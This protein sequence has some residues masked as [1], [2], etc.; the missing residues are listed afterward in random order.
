MTEAPFDAIVIGTGFGGAVAACRLAQAGKKVCILER[1]RRYP[2]HDF[3]RPAKRSDNLPYTARFAWAIDHGLWDVKDLQGVLAVQ[4]AGYGGGSLV[5]ANVHLRPPTRIFATAPDGWPA[6]YRDRTE[7]EPF[8]DIVAAALRVRPLPAQL[9]PPSP[10]TRLPK[11]DAL[12]QV[13]QNLGRARS[14]FMPPLAIDFGACVMCAECVAGCQFHAK[15]TLDLNYLAEAEKF[16]DV[17]VRTLAEVVAMRVGTDGTY[18]V[19]YLDHITGGIEITVQGNSVFLCAG[20]V[21]STDILLRSK[22]SLGIDEASRPQIGRRFFGNGDAIAMVFDTTNGQAPTPTVGP[23]IATTLL[24]NAGAPDLRSAPDAWFVLQDGGYPTWLAAALGLFRGEFWLERNRIT[25]G[26]GAPPRFDAAA[27]Q[28]VMQ[29]MKE[30]QAALVG[31]LD[32]R[33]AIRANALQGRG[34]TPTLNLD[35]VLP[36]QIR[37]L[38]TELQSFALG[39]EKKHAGAVSRDTLEEVAARVKRQPLTPDWLVD[40]AKEFAA[41]QVL[42][43]TLEIL[44]RYFLNAP[45][46]TAQPFTPAIL[47]PLV[48]SWAERL[49]LDRKPGDNAL[50]MLAVGVDAAPGHLFIDDDD[51]LLAYWDLAGNVPFA[52][53]QERLMQDVAGSLGGELRLNPDWTSRQRPVTVHCL[54]GCAMADAAA[55]GVTDP[56]GKVWGTRGLYVLDGAAIPTSLGMNPSATIAALAERNVRK[57][58]ADPTSPVFTQTPLPMDRGVPSWPESMTLTEIRAKL[59]HT[60]QV[61]DPAGGLPS[62]APPLAQ[63][64]GLTFREVMQGFYARESLVNLPIRSDFLA[65]IDD[66]NVFLVDPRRPVDIKGTVTLKPA[67]EATPVIYTASGTLALL[68]RAETVRAVEGLFK[69]WLRVS[70]APRS[71]SEANVEMDWLL[72]RLQRQAFRFEMVYDLTLTGGDGPLH[73]N[74]VKRIGWK[75]GL[76]V[77]QETTTLEVTLTDAAE[78]NV[79]HGTMHVH[80][81]DFLGTQL[82]SFTITGTDDSVRIAWAFGRFFRFF[83]GTLRQVYLPNLETLD[84]FGDRT[85]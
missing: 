53:T 21:N 47:W 69:E 81:A 75:R 13:A 73:F 58:L 20:A 19:T 71:M 52:S 2:L 70:S 32:A 26:Q 60:E 28:A 7:L 79:G 66:L 15:N 10:V 17:D 84:P 42:G 6:I 40:K 30:M 78:A 50:L 68:K 44:H 25:R 82:P 67:P 59:G 74:G 43:A 24:Y 61:L 12:R 83:F 80:I 33:A 85:S 8:Y 37:R 56:N 22:D 4:G 48:V 54:G 72:Q 64:V 23:T 36:P 34:P 31:L 76:S 3:P 9:G 65:T 46:D 18:S 29:R 57:A 45:K 11:V 1:G 27:A 41:P 55:N 77:W 5:Y 62:S 49:F 14:F 38:E 35:E 51:R 16:P 63:A 39:F